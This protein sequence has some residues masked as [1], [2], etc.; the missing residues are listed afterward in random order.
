VALGR[1]LLSEPRMLLLDEPLAAL[2]AARKAEV[3]PF[4]RAVCTGAGV[5]ILYVSHSDDEIAALAGRVLRME[6]GRL[7]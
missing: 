6:A 5:P 7:V 3:L 4:L 1:A 2:D